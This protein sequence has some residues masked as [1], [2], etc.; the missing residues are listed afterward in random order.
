M[1]EFIF[2]S[3]ILAFIAV[4]YSY[5]LT[6]PGEIL[7]GIFKKLD[8]FFK[9][10]KRACAGKGPNPLFKMIMRCEKCVAG[11]MSCWSFLYYSFDRYSLILH[12]GFISMTI[13]ITPIIK[14]FYQKY[15]E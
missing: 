14:R 8:A 6:Q 13:F 10:D 3:F 4:V 2:F 11:Q 1:I 15:A 7:S 5:I 9:T 12:I